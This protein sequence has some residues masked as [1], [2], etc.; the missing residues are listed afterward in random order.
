MDTKKQKANLTPDEVLSKSTYSMGLFDFKRLD[1]ILRVVDENAY[2]VRLDARTYMYP[3]NSI[4]KQLYINLR[5]I[6]NIEDKTNFDNRFIELKT[7]MRDNTGN[8]KNGLI[9]W[10]LE[11]VN[12]DLLTVQIGRAHV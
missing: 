6:M 3:Y 5:P 10:K 4:L 9:V 8:S 1:A 11:L 7:L 12:I 2:N